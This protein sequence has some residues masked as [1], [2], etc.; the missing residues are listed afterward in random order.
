[1]PRPPKSGGAVFVPR[2]FVEERKK[3][4]QT[5]TRL[6]AAPIESPQQSAAELQH[7]I[8]NRIREHFLDETDTVR[9]YC[10]KRT[11]PAG[12]NIERFERILRGEIMI[13]LTDLMFWASVI[14]N[15]ATF[16]G[17][18][19]GELVSEAALETPE[20]AGLDEDQ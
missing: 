9:S 1:M 5:A 12:L 13:T 7:A 14:P 2:S 18:K 15:F 17:A 19:V 16:I 3:F 8:G 20:G 4:G 10:E 11:L 6:T